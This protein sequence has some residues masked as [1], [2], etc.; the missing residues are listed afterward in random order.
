VT[1]V[2]AEAQV[3]VSTTDAKLSWLLRTWTLAEA[4]PVDSAEKVIC[5]S[6][7]T[8]GFDRVMVK[9]LLEFVPAVQPLK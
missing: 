3:N 4:A 2:P 5:V 8:F 1:K 7:Y 6:E 9:N